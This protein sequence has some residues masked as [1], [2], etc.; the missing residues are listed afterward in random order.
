[1]TDKNKI[2]IFD[3]TL[4]DG[5]QC[6][7]AS[8]DEKAKL[9]VAHQLADLNVDI[10]EAGFPITSPG[11]AQA[12]KR[13]AKEVKGP[14]ICGLARAVQKDIDVALERFASRRSVLQQAAPGNCTP[15]VD[16]D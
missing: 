8:M 16:R 12:V 7:G 1:M 11:D 5:E 4:R 9:E 15:L 13:I 14:V 6:P 10:I 3:T 2:F